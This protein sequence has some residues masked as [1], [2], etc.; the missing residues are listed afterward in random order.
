MFS[1]LIGPSFP[2]HLYT[3]AAKSGGVINNP[4]NNT[5][6]W[7]CDVPNEQ[8]EVMSNNGS[9]H[10][11][12]ACF[13]FPTLTDELDAKGYSWRYYAPPA[14]GGFG[15]HWSAFN[16]IHHMRYGKDWQ[17]VVSTQQ[18]MEDASSGNLP[19]VSCNNAR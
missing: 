17:Y 5:A 4:P 1:S 19:T 15:Y 8:V 12:N 2:N 11:Q 9:T 13:N 16:A 18:F 14:E 3:I 10:L 7:G 6:G